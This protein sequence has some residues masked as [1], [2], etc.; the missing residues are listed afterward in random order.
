[1]EFALIKR[2]TID[3]C[4]FIILGYNSFEIPL[5]S[6]DQVDWIVVRIHYHMYLGAYTT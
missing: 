6:L 5:H 4:I 3:E 2:I 1:M